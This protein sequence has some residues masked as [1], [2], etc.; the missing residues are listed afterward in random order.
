MVKII[1]LITVDP[2]FV[3]RGVK[4]EN[5]SKRATRWGDLGRSISSG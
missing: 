3:L 2:L 1:S 5:R 4:G